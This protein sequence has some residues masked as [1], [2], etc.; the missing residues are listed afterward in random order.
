MPKQWQ[1]NSGLGKLDCPFFS[2]SRTKFAVESEVMFYLD[3]RE[4]CSRIV[5]FKE[6]GKRF[7]AEI[8]ASGVL[9][10]HFGSVE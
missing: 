7:V 8:F 1:R 5:E 3:D 4:W 10:R 9:I 2:S 6:K